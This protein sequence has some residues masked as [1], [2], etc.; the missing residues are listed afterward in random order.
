MGFE[1]VSSVA[2][3]LASLR[4]G[5]IAY[6]LLH[7]DQRELID[8]EVKQCQADEQAFAEAVLRGDPG[9]CNLLIDGL[10]HDG[11]SPLLTVGEADRLREI[12]PAID[13]ATLLRL[14]ALGREGDLA[15]RVSQIIQTADGPKK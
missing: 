7:K 5:D 12:V 14:Y 1:I 3:F 9:T 8:A 15:V 4:I 10:R 11:P 2:D 13:G 6:D